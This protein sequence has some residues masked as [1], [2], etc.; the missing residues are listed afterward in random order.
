MGWKIFRCPIFAELCEKLVDNVVFGVR[1]DYDPGK[2]Q[3]L[4]SHIMEITDA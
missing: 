2:W 1:N 4:V 3:K